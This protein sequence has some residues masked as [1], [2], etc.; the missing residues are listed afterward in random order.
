MRTEEME[1]CIHKYIYKSQ[2][3]NF[4]KQIKKHVNLIGIKLFEYLKFPLQ[5]LKHFIF[6][7]LSSNLKLKCDSLNLFFVT[8]VAS[9][10][11]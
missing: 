6:G 7:R 5:K 1:T 11:H 10:T 2:T 8:D 4:T 9:S 3:I